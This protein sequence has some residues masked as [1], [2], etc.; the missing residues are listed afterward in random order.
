MPSH[1][2][3][4]KAEIAERFGFSTR[5]VD[6]LVVRGLLAKPVKLGR[7][8]QSRVRWPAAAVAQLERNLSSSSTSRI[9]A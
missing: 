9:A 4:S 5:T 6:N 7:F 8:P 3:F 1:R 2:Y